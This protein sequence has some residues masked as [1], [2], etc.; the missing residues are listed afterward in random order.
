MAYFNTV[1]YVTIAST[2]NAT[3]FGDLTAAKTGVGSCASPTRAL[4]GA[5]YDGSETVTIEYF[6]IA[7]TGNGT[8]FGDLRN[9]DSEIFAGSSY[10]RGV[11]QA[12]GNNNPPELNYV[13]IA[14][15]GNASDFGDIEDGSKSGG[16]SNGHGGL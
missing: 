15:L 2:G 13:T 14:S 4:V 16:A 6:T 12:G 3:D 8:D 9:I 10:V 11:F 7:T 1:D 5:G